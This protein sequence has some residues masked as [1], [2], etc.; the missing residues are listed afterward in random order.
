[1]YALNEPNRRQSLQ[2]VAE[3]GTL[4]EEVI[5]TVRTAQAF[6]SQS[7]LGAL[8]D[9]KM[10]KIRII[11]GKSALWSGCTM[12]VFFFV[13]FA[14]YALGTYEYTLEFSCRYI[15]GSLAFSFGTTLINQ[16]HGVFTPNL[17]PYNLH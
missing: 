12:G 7:V 14:A 15:H 16:G 3:S 8:F 4:A 13:L 9:K 11:D 10:S 6:G 17:P 1:M 5:S 2:Q